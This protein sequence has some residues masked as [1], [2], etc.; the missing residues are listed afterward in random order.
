MTSTAARACLQ[1]YR[2]ENV[3]PVTYRHLIRQYG[4]AAEALT[5]LPDL[6]TRGGRKK[7]LR[8]PKAKDIEAE[9]K[10]GEQLGAT[11]MTHMDAGFSTPLWACEDAPPLLWCLGS[12]SLL[13]QP[14][15]GIVGARN[16]SANGQRVAGGIAQELSGAGYVVASGLA[17]G[18]D[19]AAHAGALN[20]PASTIAVLAGGLDHIYPKEHA[21]LYTAIKEQG[22]IVS[23]MAPGVIAQAR[24]FPRR[25]RIISGLS[26]GVLVVEAARKS[27]SLITA[28]FAAEQG[29]PV[30]AV[31]GHP[32]D[33]RA[34]GPN[35]LIR[36]GA[37]LVQSAKDILDD[38]RPMTPHVFEE[39]SNA[40]SS[41][42]AHPPSDPELSRARPQI[43]DLLGPTP[44]LID[45]VIRLSDQ[46]PAVVHTIILELE[47]AGR[48]Q[49]HAGQKVSV[50]TMDER[51]ATQSSALPGT[52][53]SL[54]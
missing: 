35:D 7:T 48:L 42:P 17:R 38:I 25:N 51:E 13:Q 39:P 24:H 27:G 1:L 6:A 37:T 26:L 10:A 15:F 32:M 41:V 36:N 30:F 52:Q 45:E 8:I 49:R 19:G 12:P 23:E 34:H 2:T 28:R 29:R 31:P 53:A 14:T 50:T 33:Q 21:D 43:H 3:G 9:I 5:V 20:E 47:L 22:L 4:S 40:F 54:F 18:T 44:T 16:A 11:L 46:S